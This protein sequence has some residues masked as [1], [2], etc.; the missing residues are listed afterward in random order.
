[1][2]STCERGIL[3]RGSQ[4]FHVDIV[5]RINAFLGIY[6]FEEEVSLGL[7]AV[8]NGCIQLSFKPGEEQENEWEIKSSV[9][10]H[11]NLPRIK[12]VK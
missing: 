12:K 1:M 6:P 5:N 7:E 9:R 4:I 3:W 8:I 2:D 11:E 10:L